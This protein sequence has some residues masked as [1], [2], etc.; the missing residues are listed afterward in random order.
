[1]G[2]PGSPAR[3]ASDLSPDAL[4]V[5]LKTMFQPAA[6]DDQAWRYQLRLGEHAFAVRAGGREIEVSCG[7]LAPPAE[8][9]TTDPATLAALL[10]HGRR[11]EE[12]ITAGTLTASGP[13]RALVQFFARFGG[14]ATA[15]GAAE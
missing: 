3:R 13:R 12:A 10:W 4:A 11:L 1:M 2:E 7:E 15:E 6:D 14:A 9:I 5:A 8:T